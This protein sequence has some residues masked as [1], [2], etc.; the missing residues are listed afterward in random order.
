MNQIRKAYSLEKLFAII[1]VLAGLLMIIIEPPISGPD[2]RVHFLNTYAVSTGQLIPKASNGVM[3][4]EFPQSVLSFVEQHS[5]QFGGSN[6]LEEKVAFRDWYY[7]SW[8]PTTEDES[9]EITYWDVDNH[10]AGYMV[11]GIGMMIFRILMSFLSPDF[12]TPYNLI[13]A[14][15][16]GNLFFYVLLCFFAIRIAPNYK[17]LLFVLALM[18]MSIYQAASLNY[19][20][21]LISVCFLLFAFVLRVVRNED[22]R[23]SNRDIFLVMLITF[24]LAGI[25][26]VYLCLLVALFGIPLKRFKDKKQYIRCIVLVLTTAAVTYGMHEL[27][28]GTLDVVPTAE[29]MKMSEQFNYVMAHPFGIFSAIK[30]SL[31]NY[32][33]FY[34][35]S[36]VGIFGNLDI[37]IPVC[38]HLLFWIVLAVVLIADSAHCALTLKVKA[39]FMGGGILSGIASFLGIYL[40]W[41]SI[42]Q[43]IGVD[44]VDG[45]QGRYFI[46]LAP[47]MLTFFAVKAFPNFKCW[48]S[49]QESVDGITVVSGL[50]SAAITVTVL[51]LRFWI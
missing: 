48:N 36:F 38:F 22:Y 10:A 49:I 8:L 6:Q 28:V 31:V 1:A 3:V 41:T 45:V 30:N 32:R 15:K 26:Q 29:A 46:P 47:F 14:G 17:R 35:T 16:M 44:L 34:I 12:I 19:D 27:A 39:L 9:V 11:A 5:A 40:L 2:E 18:P 4:K 42:T 20:A 24:F 50:A 21:V 7:D 13:M 23:I 43:G 33:G 37:N 25:K 51:I